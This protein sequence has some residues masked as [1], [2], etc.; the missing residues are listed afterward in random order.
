MSDY[1]KNI[2]RN[3]SYPIQHGIMT[4]SFEME[5]FLLNIF[6]NKRI[7]PQDYKL[8]IALPIFY[9]RDKMERLAKFIFESCCAQALYI[10]NQAV[11]P[12]I[13]KGRFTGFSLESG[14]GI[15][16]LVPIYDGFPLK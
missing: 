4:D 8:F 14:E 15:T 7:S 6:E 3:Y 1:Y 12:L 9:P 2:N 10:G 5:E 11:F 16:Q 13:S